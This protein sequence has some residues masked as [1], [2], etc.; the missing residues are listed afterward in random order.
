MALKTKQELVDEV[1]YE[2]YAGMPSNTRSI[3]DNFVVRIL[4]NHIAEAAVKSAYASNNLDGIVAADDIFTLTY[5]MPLSTDTVTGNK[6]FAHPAQP[7]GLPNK[8]AMTI[9]PPKTRG[10][11][12]SSIFKGILRSDVT[13]VRSMP[14]I[15]KVFH[16]T[17]NGNEYFLDTVPSIMSGYSS[18]NL[19]IVSS[20]AN[21]LTAFVNLP[22]DMIA[23][24]KSLC[25]A[26]CRQMLQL[27]DIIPLTPQDNPQPRK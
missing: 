21:D 14:T 4:N 3:S 7:V 15:K 20:G 6:Y 18:V 5:T 16:Y 2:V 10:G 1:I 23:S 8:R 26:E 27:T 11:V 19:S 22:D 13:K 9:F 12:M 17:E 24:V 25:I